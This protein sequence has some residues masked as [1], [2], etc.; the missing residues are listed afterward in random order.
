MES[1]SN[2]V[3]SVRAWRISKGLENEPD[4]LWNEQDFLWNP[5][6]SLENEQNFLWNPQGVSLRNEPLAE[7]NELADLQMK[8]PKITLL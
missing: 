7:R 1:I 5:Q 3:H 8:H 4:S 6:E 2:F